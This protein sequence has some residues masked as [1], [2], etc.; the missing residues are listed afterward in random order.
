MHALSFRNV[1]LLWGLAIVTQ[2]LY[3][4]FDVNYNLALRSDE[5]D[6]GSSDGL[7]IV[8]RAGRRPAKN[9]KPPKNLV[10]PTSKAPVPTPSAT[11]VPPVTPIP[12][13][14][15]ASSSSKSRPSSSA[16]KS[17]SSSSTLKTSSLSQSISTVQVSSS[18]GASS[19]T[20]G[21]LPT[22]GSPTRT[23]SSSI[24]ATSSSTL[25]TATASDLYCPVAGAIGKPTGKATVK[26]PRAIGKPMGKPTGKPDDVCNYKPTPIPTK[27]INACDYL[28][29]CQVS[30]ESE[31]IVE[32]TN[33]KP[34]KPTKG[35]GTK[36]VKRQQKFSID[37]SDSDQLSARGEPRRYKTDVEGV[38]KLEIYS[39][40]YP[41][42]SD[43]YTGEG[44]DVPKVRV[45]WKSDKLSDF[46]V[47]VYKTLPE[48]NDYSGLVT[49]HLIELQTVKMFIE[50]L[51]KKT[52]AG[53]V[54]G[55][56][57]E[58]WWNEDLSTNAVPVGTRTNKATDLTTG[59]DLGIQTSINDLVFQALGSMENRADFVLCDSEINTFKMRT[60]MKHNY[61]ELRKFENLL[62]DFIEGAMHSNEVLSIFRTI[63]GV[64]SYMNKQEVKDRLIHSYE[65]VR[66]EL[67]NIPQLTQE[68]KDLDRKWTAFMEGHLESIGNHGKNWLTGRYTATKAAYQSAINALVAQKNALND[69]KGKVLKKDLQAHQAEVKRLKE[70][71]IRLKKQ[72]DG[73]YKDRAPLQ[74]ALYKAIK[75]KNQAAINKA[76]GD[77]KVNDLTLDS[78][79]VDIAENMRDTNKAERVLGTQLVQ[80][81]QELIDNLKRDQTTLLA[82][83]AKTPN[84]QMPT[85]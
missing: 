79:K 1:L 53:K 43:L 83:E 73:A 2:G 38:S 29:D 70:S 12:S 37:L 22:T 45:E 78:L 31:P 6:H 19:S 24:S 26:H 8:P 30:D 11:K 15:K 14:S 34:S 32:D 16:S 4:P 58:K 82:F 56:W 46:D 69:N 61:M 25:A 77:L 5:A 81:V 57:F 64:F 28:I 13:S 84:L 10:K 36:P 33:N 21:S 75:T 42:N 20:R 40:D 47:R 65:N 39:L 67:S 44:A 23:L 59:N 80:N 48:K 49:E 7:N 54:E 60:W 72:L 3:V 66:K 71:A 62:E 41:S 9:S 35:K 74:T 27:A 18:T 76:D 85:L 50:S 68:N 55:S 52:D 51:V 63:F 17:L